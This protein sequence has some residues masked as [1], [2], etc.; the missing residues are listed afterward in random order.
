MTKQ[1]TLLALISAT[2]VACSGRSPTD[3]SQTQLEGT[4][5]G[6]K[7]EVIA[8]GGIAGLDIRHVVSQDDRFFVYTQRR[9]CTNNCAASDSASGTL[10]VA[11]SDALFNLVFAQLPFDL[12]NDYGT[13]RGAADM[14]EYTIRITIGGDAVKTIRADDGTMPEQ[15]RR[16]VSAVQS[17]VS[18]ARK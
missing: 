13:S 4:K 16:I 17:T 9:L 10:S 7:V 14:M 2:I 18:A 3:A 11:A 5:S 6:S 12:K 15:L 1:T 8:E